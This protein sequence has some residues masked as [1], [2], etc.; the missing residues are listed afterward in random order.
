M[1]VKV[2]RRVQTVRLIGVDTPETKAPGTPV[3]CWGSQ[4]T[5]QAKRL[6]RPSRSV[7]LETDPAQ[8]RRDRFGRLL[9]VTVSRA[10]QPAIEPVTA[11]S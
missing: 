3:Q 10:V 5:A 7:R 11:G 4:A 8:A 2:G 9:P 6:M 1:K